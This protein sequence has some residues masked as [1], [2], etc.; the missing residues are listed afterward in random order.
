MNALTNHGD[1]K[2]ATSASAAGRL[3]HDY[4]VEKVEAYN[5]AIEALRMHEPAS[6]CDRALAAGLR[7]RLARKLEREIQRWCDANPLPADRDA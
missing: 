4:W 2:P 3:S 7:E 1:T 6:D 5:V